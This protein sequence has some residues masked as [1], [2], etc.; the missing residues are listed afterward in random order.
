MNTQVPEWLE[1]VK[2]NELIRNARGDVF[3][4]TRSIFYP[5]K[6]HIQYF[7]AAH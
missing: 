4:P 7:D 2:K 3:N 1:N 6:F 5:R